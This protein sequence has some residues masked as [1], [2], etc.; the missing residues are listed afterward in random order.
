MPAR[1]ND[2]LDGQAEGGELPE[3]PAV[4]AST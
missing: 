4:A 1:R 3:R 2:E